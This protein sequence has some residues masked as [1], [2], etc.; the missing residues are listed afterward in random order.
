VVGV[1]EGEP[2]SSIRIAEAIGAKSAA[3]RITSP[4]VLIILAFISIPP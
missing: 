3:A 4:A 1:T 2:G